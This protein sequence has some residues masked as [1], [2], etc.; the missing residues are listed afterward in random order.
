MA[1]T[2]FPEAL[3]FFNNIRDKVPDAD[4]LLIIYEEL[5]QLKGEFYAAQM[6]RDAYAD[7]SNNINEI[8]G[9]TANV[10]LTV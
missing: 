1:F 4:E 7:Y 9:R 6:L 3:K 2:K 10:G 8:I 5:L